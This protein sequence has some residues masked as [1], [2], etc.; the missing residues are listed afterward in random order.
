MEDTNIDTGFD[1]FAAAFDDDYQTGSEGSAEEVETTDENTRGADDGAQDTSDSEEHQEDGG[2]GTEDPDGAGTD[3]GA[4]QPDTFTLKVNK[5]ERTVNREEVI[6]L[7]Q[8]GAD[9]DRVK[10]Q[11][12]ESSTTI[13]QLQS[14]IGKYQNAIDILEMISADSGKN[15][16]ELVEQ[17]HLNMLTMGGKTEAEAKAE[18]RAIKAERALNAAKSQES[19]QKAA[20]DD[21]AGRAQREVAE[22]RKRFPD[23]DLSQELCNELMADV[24]SGMTLSDAYQKREMARKDAEIAELNRK[25]DAEKQNKK[26]RATTP[27]SQNDSGGRREKSDFDDFMSAFE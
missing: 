11:L 2:L 14:Q 16:D 23:V 4:A 5:E 1:E 22:F 13:Q 27:G 17:M 21:S 7:A 20:Q 6:A 8:K 26:N 3:N 24:K 18:I 15:V 9:Y 10:G 25:L 12:A 19:S